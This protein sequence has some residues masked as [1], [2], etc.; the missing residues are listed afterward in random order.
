VCVEI[1]FF[2]L[3]LAQLIICL[4]FRRSQFDSWVRRIPWRRDRLRT[5]VFLGF[6]IDS[7]GKESPVF[8]SGES[9]GQRATVHEVSKSWTQLSKHSTAHKISR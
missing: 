4:Q 1:Y 8:L 2:H 6:P 7:D 9:Q 5:P 3:A